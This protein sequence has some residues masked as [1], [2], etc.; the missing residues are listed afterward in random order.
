MKKGLLSFLFVCTLAACLSGCGKQEETPE[1]A[2]PKDGVYTAEYLGLSPD[3]S[4]LELALAAYA[5]YPLPE[6]VDCY[7]L[8]YIDNDDIPECFFGGENGVNGWLSFHD[9][10][11]AEC[12]TKNYAD[13]ILYD[14]KSQY[15]CFYNG[16]R[17]KKLIT[18]S[19]DYFKFESDGTFDNAGYACYRAG[20]KI[21]T[22]YDTYPK[23][24]TTEEIYIKYKSQFGEMAS[25]FDG[26]EEMYPTVEAAYE[27][28]QTQ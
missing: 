2:P 10:L 4:E 19:F 15:I 11:V 24:D 6:T 27:A 16:V 21:A 7:H 18:D 13:K 23:R 26:Y 12:W 25:S 28:L 3:A 17:N 14:E 8:A 22:R 20:E 9:G 1:I 5:S